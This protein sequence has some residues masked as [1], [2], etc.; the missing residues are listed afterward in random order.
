VG[1]KETPLPRGQWSSPVTWLGED[2][3]LEWVQGGRPTQELGR[4]AF[5]L[6]DLLQQLGALRP[7]AARG[8]YVA[9]F[10][11]LTL[12]LRSEGKVDALRADFFTRIHCPRE[13]EMVK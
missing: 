8:V 1:A 4:H 9:E 6:L 12:K 5:S 11:P 3:K 13:L 10:P 7:A 2:T